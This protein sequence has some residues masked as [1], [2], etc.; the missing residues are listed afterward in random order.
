MSHTPHSSL[1]SKLTDDINDILA[2]TELYKPSIEIEVKLHTAYKDLGSV[3]G[4]SMLSMLQVRDYENNISDYIEI[5]LI[6]SLGT[7]IYDIYPYLDNIEVTLVYYDQI[8][9]GSKPIK[10]LQRYKAVYLKD[11]NDKIPTILNVSIDDL[12]QQPPVT[13]TLQL[14]DRSAEVLRIKTISGNFEPKINGTK[15]VDVFLRSIIAAQ[16]V[17]VLVDNKPAIEAV[18]VEKADN[19]ENIASVT[20]PSYTRLIDVPGYIQQ[21]S[22]GVYTSGIGAY[23]QLF[24]EKKTFFVYSLYNAKKYNKQEYKTIFYAP[25][26]SSVIRADKTYLYKDKTLKVIVEPLTKLLDSRET[27]MMNKGSGFRVSNARSFMKKP[28]DMTPQGPKVNRSN[29]NT[30]V[31][32]NKRKDNLDYSP[33]SSQ[34]ISANVFKHTS[35]VIKANGAYVDLKWYNSNIRY[36]YPGQACKIVTEDKNNKV[37]EF[38]GVIISIHTSTQDE[39]NSP[40]LKYAKSTNYSSVSSIKIFVTNY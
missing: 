20:I 26:D 22:A 37:T 3:D 33:I 13:L 14:I 25:L 5:R 10:V 35:N 23:I 4:L 2:S 7:Y 15:K 18:D 27:D 29:L 16:C 21:R 19:V 8:Y 24:N 36:I 11:L 17:K 1:D 38:Y 30:E 31:V 28:V 34:R 9:K 32:I 6:V 39:T 12:N 40:V